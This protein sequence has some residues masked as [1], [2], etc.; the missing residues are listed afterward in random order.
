V[1]VITSFKPQKNGKR[2]N[3][4][5]DDKFGFGIDLINFAQNNL[6]IGLE[7]TDEKLKEIVRKAEFQKTLDKTLRFATL[8]PRSEKEI[9]DYF[10]RK[11][12][13]ESIH[14]ELFEKLKH[15]GLIDDEA[16][17]KW[18]IEQRMSFK[19][20]GK[21]ALLN[22]LA[23]KGIKKEVSEEVL[24]KLEINESVVARDLIVRN[25]RKWERYDPKDASKKKA[26]YLARKGFSWDVVKGVL[27]I[28]DE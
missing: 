27:S 23:G 15:F 5:I 13:H 6:K 18:W 19:P 25:A 24:G 28:D 4:Y 8:R 11:K 20:K 26:E 9:K 17:T 14:A 22:E 1:P 2:V 10:R 7:L 3:V 12:V 21:K 16:F